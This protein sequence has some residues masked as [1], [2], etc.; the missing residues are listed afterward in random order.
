MPLAS[1][2]RGPSTLRKRERIRAR[3]GPLGGKVAAHL[4]QL[5]PFVDERPPLVEESVG[6]LLKRLDAVEQR[7]DLRIAALWA[8]LSTIRH[9]C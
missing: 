5:R 8:K 3:A 2:G 9:V 1:R 4:E 7:G 6:P